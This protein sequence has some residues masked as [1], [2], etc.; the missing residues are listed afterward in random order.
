MKTIKKTCIIS[1][2]K[3][4]HILSFMTTSLIVLYY[5]RIKFWGQMDRRTDR[6]SIMPVSCIT[7]KRTITVFKKH[8]DKGLTIPKQHFSL[9]THKMELLGSQFFWFVRSLKYF[10]HIKPSQSADWANGITWGKPSDH[11]QAEKLEFPQIWSEQG[12]EHSSV[13]SGN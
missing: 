9:Y 6:V 8:F 2:S 5:C 12:W 10:G 7:G 1:S 13:G 11:M 4:I 3:F